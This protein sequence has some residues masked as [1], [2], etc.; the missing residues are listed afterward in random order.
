V[1]YFIFFPS[2]YF[3][4]SHASV[5]NIYIY[6]SLFLYHVLVCIHQVYEKRL[7]HTDSQLES[8]SSDP[9][10]LHRNWGQQF[11]QKV[12]QRILKQC[13]LAQQHRQLQDIVMEDQVPDIG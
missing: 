2:V 13:H 8:L 1:V 4:S 5:V 3:S 7:T 6:K 9:L 10:E 12:R 11:L